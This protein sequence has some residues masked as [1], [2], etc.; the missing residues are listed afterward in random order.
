VDCLGAIL[1]HGH[2]L[3]GDDGTCTITGTTAGNLL[4]VPAGLKPLADNGGFT[5][6]H[7]L[8]RH[9]KAIDHGSPKK[10]GSGGRACDRHDQR[11]VK[12]PQGKRCDIGAYERKRHRHHHH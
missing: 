9:S 6:T 5:K 11:G 7:A 10:P 3:I 8:R 4:N 2:D 12:R 1:S